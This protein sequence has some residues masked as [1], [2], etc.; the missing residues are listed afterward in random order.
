[1]RTDEYGTA[2]KING[3]WPW[4]V[5]TYYRYNPSGYFRRNVVDD[6][7]WEKNHKKWKEKEQQEGGIKAT[8]KPNILGKVQM[9]CT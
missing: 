8:G 7:K 5:I 3:M 2:N 1:M 4:P 6:D 9:S